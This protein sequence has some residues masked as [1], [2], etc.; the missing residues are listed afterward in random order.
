[1]YPFIF[2]YAV[3]QRVKEREDFGE[4]MREAQMIANRLREQ[5]QMELEV[6]KEGEVRSEVLYL[7]KAGCHEFQ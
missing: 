5:Y 4:L 1:M 3:L 6:L 2:T 7:T